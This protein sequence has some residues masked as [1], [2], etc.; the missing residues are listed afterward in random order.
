MNDS[1]ESLI[2]AHSVA[3]IIAL[4]INEIPID[5]DASY[6][7]AQSASKL[8]IDF[9]LSPMFLDPVAFLKSDGNEVKIGDPPTRHNVQWISHMYDSVALCTVRQLIL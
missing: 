7:E 5:T 8:I 4:V 3:N 6:Q 1:V 2:E 9:L